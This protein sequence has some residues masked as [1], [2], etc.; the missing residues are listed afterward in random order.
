MPTRRQFSKSLLTASAGLLVPDSPLWFSEPLSSSQ[1]ANQTYDLLIKGGTVIDPGQDLHAPLDVAVKDG[2]IVELSPD[3]PADKSRKVISASGRL[4]TPGLIDL[5]VHIYEGVTESGLN[6][7]HS[8]IARGVTTAVDAGSAGYPSIAGFRQYIVNA[9]ATRIYA[10]LD[11]GALGT[12]VGV[13]DA[14]ENL[15]WVNPQL[16]AKAANANKPTVVG[17]KAR[18]SK[19]IAGTNDVEVL[20]RAREAAEDSRLPMMLHVGDTN[21]PLRDILRSVRRGDVITHCYTPRPHGILDE[22]GKILSEVREARQ[23]GILFDVGHGTFHFGFDLTEE[24][25]QQDFLPDTI[26][27]DLAG[28]SVNG[29]TFDFTTTLSKFLLLGLTVDKVVELATIRPAHTFSF[30]LELGMLKPGNAADISI[31]DLRQG[32]FEF[33]DCI[34]GK[35]IGRQKLFSVATIRDGKLFEPNKDL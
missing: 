23:R 22:N 15:E 26:S 34:G 19:D 9:S 13:K 31:L 18:L 4:V 8:C 29:P 24:C 32:N 10:L 16:T 3:I 11:I 33:V 20:K 28:R 1:N 14:M 2:K 5:H 12:L 30:G 7:D 25:L 17:I 6:A 35:R 21:S 27:S